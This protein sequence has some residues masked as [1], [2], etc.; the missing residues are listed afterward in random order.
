MKKS[1]KVIATIV[2]VVLVVTAMVVAIYAATAGNVGINANVSWTAQEGVSLEFWATATGGDQEKSVERQTIAPTTA[3]ADAKIQG[4]LSCN[5]VDNTDDGVNNPGAITFTYCVKNNS[6]TKLNVRVTDKPE[7]GEESGTS[8]DDHKPQVVLSSS[9][10]NSGTSTL[11][12]VLSSSGCDLTSNQTLKFEVVLSMRS[13]GTGSINADTGLMKDF[14]AGVDFLFNVAGSSSSANS[15]KTVIDGVETGTPIGDV[16][17]QTL[18]T[19]LTSIEPTYCAGWFFDE[20]LSQAVTEENL[21]AEIRSDA[22][23][24]NLYTKTASIEGLTFTASGTGYEVKQTS[25]SSV[26]GNIVI[27]Y[28]YNGKYVIEMASNAFAYNGSVTSVILPSTITKL[29]NAFYRCSGL[30]NIIIPDNVTSIEDGPFMF[31]SGLTSVI[32]GNGVTSLDGTAFMG[33]DN[34]TTL[35]IGNNVKSVIQMPSL[36]N[37]KSLTV[38]SGLTDLSALLLSINFSELTS[39]EIATGNPKY[40][41]RDNCNAV[42]ETASNTLIKCSKSIVIPDS[43]TS[44]GDESFRG[45]TFTSFIIPNNIT[46]IGNFAFE[47]CYSLTSVTLPNNLISIGNGAFTY[48]TQ[49]TSITIP[50]SV[51]TMGGA[52]FSSCSA[53]TSI[54]IPANVGSIGESLCS[55]TD[56]L[57]TINVASGNKKYDSR[58]NCNAIIE[59]SSNKLIAGCKTSV[60]PSTVT[61]IA[62]D[63][64]TGCSGLTSIT[65]PNGVTSIAERAF[66]M[67]GDLI[68]VFIPASV[69]SISA[70][71]AFD[72]P[73]SSCSSTLKIYCEAS[74]KQDGWGDYWN[75]YDSSSTCT[76]Y[77]SQTL[78]DFNAA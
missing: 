63:S 12:A 34:L 62:K 16:A 72:S 70:T 50:D 78:A 36:A 66:S 64:F 58:N 30:T 56:E 25:S 49:L 55:F 38:G 43:V 68:K 32:I 52:V 67:C 10:D 65:I 39:L 73:V 77:W 61:S 44:L 13:G 6:L 35:V 18:G 46:S 27:P 26:S 9:I 19:Y 22:E 69:T 47:S 57:V 41:S 76:T 37:M 7:A 51:T 4:D 42:I 28:K 40:D 20:D 21:N 14:D 23:A 8:K 2:A 33:C 3:N 45:R 24:T 11:A 5:F 71:N 54:T 31:C 15:L 60:I 48:C 1:T 59:T 29:S 74:S 53:L 17:G 75:N